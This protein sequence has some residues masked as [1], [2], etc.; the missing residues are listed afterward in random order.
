MRRVQRIAI[1]KRLQKHNHVVDLGIRPCGGSPFFTHERLVDYIDVSAQPRRK[2]IKL[3]YQAAREPGIPQSRLSEEHRVGVTFRGHFCER[4]SR[5]RWAGSI[6]KR[7]SVRL[8]GVGHLQGNT[9]NISRLHFLRASS[10]LGL[11]VALPAFYLVRQPAADSARPV[12]VNTCLIT[13]NFAQLVD[14][15]KNVLGFSPSV[16]A[17]NYAEFSTAAGVLAIFSADAQE[18]YIPGSATAAQNR[19]AILEFRVADVDGEYARL[20]TLVTAW[21]KPPTNQPWGTRSFY[22]RD[23]DG[24]LVDFYAPIKNR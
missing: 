8:C 20:Q 11:F 5:N 7:I 23:P 19:S 18:K 12:L 10:F 22:F 14:F 15:Y 6:P 3:I 4:I 16:T 24:N 13:A 1:R 9:V 2:I 21:V 17:G